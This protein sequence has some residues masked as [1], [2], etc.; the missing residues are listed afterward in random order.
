MLTI[1]SI[2]EKRHSGPPPQHLDFLEFFSRELGLHSTEDLQQEPKRILLFTHRQAD[3]DALCSAGGLSLLL[4]SLGGRAPL[5]T[6]IIAPLG[7]SQLGA[8][9]CRAFSIDYSENEPESEIRGA[10]LI[11]ALDLG[12][13]ELLGP[14]ADLVKSSRAHKVLIDHHGSN[15]I[16]SAKETSFGQTDHPHGFHAV[17]ADTKASSTCEI[18]ARGFPQ[19]HFS[20]EA[21]AILLVGLLF[22]SQ[23]FALATET[24]LEAALKLLKAGAQIEEAK[25]VLKNRPD[26]SEIIARIKSAQ[27]LKSEEI[28]KYILLQTEVSSFQASVA[29]M[30]LE[31]GADVA[32][33]YG[34]N[35]G[36]TRVSTRSTQRFYRESGV[37]LGKVLSE[38]ASSKASHS[39]ASEKRASGGGH[40]TAAS[41]SCAELPPKAVAEEVASR[42]RQKIP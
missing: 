9:V 4:R 35:D 21:A 14:Y 42:I 24:T 15:A 10:D 28:G 22:D 27:R 11:V 26:R 8:K 41:L 34:E 7:A 18:V 3:P 6:K 17:F 39:G 5:E 38:L 33:A 2:E 25:N 36:E 23:H 16:L 19:E 32:I 20:R 37:D 30:L 40:S 13:V 31:I 1:N 29:R 12:E